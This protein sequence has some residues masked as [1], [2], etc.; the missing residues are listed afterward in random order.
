MVKLVAENLI[1]DHLSFP[2]ER[3]IWNGRS[4][5]FVN[6]A[7]LSL[8]RVL[9]EVSFSSFEGLSSKPKYQAYFFVWFK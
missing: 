1:V 9:E 7:G 8:G 2:S 3:K 6:A 4:L 5:N